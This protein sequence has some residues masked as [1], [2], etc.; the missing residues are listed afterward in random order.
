MEALTA[1]LTPFTA[2]TLHIKKGRSKFTKNKTWK[3]KTNQ[4]IRQYIK[5]AMVH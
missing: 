4:L 5:I 3:I 2:I 1:I